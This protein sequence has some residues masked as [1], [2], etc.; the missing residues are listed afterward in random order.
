[1]SMFSFLRSSSSSS[2]NA[3]SSPAPAISQPETKDV[4]AESESG[5]FF[6]LHE[7]SSSNVHT[8]TDLAAVVDGERCYPSVY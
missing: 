1:M 2:V 7:I 5:G 3:V 4:Q 6:S 8:K